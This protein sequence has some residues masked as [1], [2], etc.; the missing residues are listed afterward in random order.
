MHPF[1]GFDHLVAMLLVGVFA[2]QLGGRAFWA[3]PGTFLAAMAT[4]G[5][6]GLALPGTPVVE[7]GIAL[8]I[9]VLGAAVALNTKTRVAVAAAAVGVFAVFHGF[10]HGAEMPAGASAM[11]YGAG[12][13]LGSAIL[14]GSGLVS[15]LALRT[16]TGRGAGTMVRSAGT[17]AAVAGAGLLT[18]LV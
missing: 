13:L 1:T 5:L 12:F 15:G 17:V 7:I 2:V 6:L 9:I 3:L 11:S 14:I 8:S 18:G 16:A 10:A 4:G